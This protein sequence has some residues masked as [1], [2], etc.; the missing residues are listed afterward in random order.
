MILDLPKV[1][2]FW[3]VLINTSLRHEGLSRSCLLPLATVYMFNF[4]F[5]RIVA[6]VFQT[7]EIMLQEKFFLQPGILS[8]VVNEFLIK[9]F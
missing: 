9:N 5:Q 2:V 1:W 3:G 8:Q 6:N 4:T 7:V